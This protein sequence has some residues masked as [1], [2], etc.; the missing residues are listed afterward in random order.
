[1]LQQECCDPCHAGEMPASALALMRSRYSAYALGLVDYIMDT[2]HPRSPIRNPNRVIWRSELL[3][4]CKETKFCGLEI[5]EFIDG[6]DT[7][8]VTF[9]ARLEQGGQ[10]VT[11]KEKSS[12]SKEGGRWFYK[13]GR[14]VK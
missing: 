9:I 6:D 14:F 2:T 10:D 11:F 13:N 12:F 1:M 8:T 5:I 7:A 4:F 3:Q